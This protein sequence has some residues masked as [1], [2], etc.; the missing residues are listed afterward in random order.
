MERGRPKAGN[1]EDT[2]RERNETREVGICW[3]TVLPSE[4]QLLERCEQ[5]RGKGRARVQDGER[6]AQC[7]PREPEHSMAAPATVQLPGGELSSPRA[8]LPGGGGDGDGLVGGE[9]RSNGLTLHSSF[10]RGGE[11]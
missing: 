10:A 3:A 6:G 5:A 8:A 7:A 11:G 1:G 9:L 2:E 4:L